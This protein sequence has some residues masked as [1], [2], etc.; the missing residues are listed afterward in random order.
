MA[1]EW[2]GKGHG[3]LLTKGSGGAAGT[4]YFASRPESLSDVDESSERIGR[5][6]VVHHTILSRRDGSCKARL[7]FASS[8]PS[9]S[10]DTVDEFTMHFTIL[11]QK[12]APIHSEFIAP[13]SN[14]QDKGNVHR[15]YRG[16]PEALL[17]NKGGTLCVSE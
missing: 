9:L 8:Q 3:A 1:S 16:T 11:T 14:D 4:L 2:P 6:Q 12:S 7:L 15:E 13:C 10:I 5:Y 17:P